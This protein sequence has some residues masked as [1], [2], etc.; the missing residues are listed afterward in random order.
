MSATWKE[1]GGGARLKVERDKRG[2]TQEQLAY[3]LGV[4]FCTVNRWENNHAEPSPLAIKELEKF[5]YEEEDTQEGVP[6]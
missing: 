3:R 4:T 6:A 1:L 5:Y 2:L